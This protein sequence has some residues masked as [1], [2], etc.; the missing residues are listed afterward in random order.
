MLIRDSC[1]LLSTNTF[2]VEA[3][4]PSPRASTLGAQ[5]RTMLRKLVVAVF[6]S[7]RSFPNFDGGGQSYLSLIGIEYA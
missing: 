2:Q 4:S 3:H 6:H 1:H 5:S 7:G